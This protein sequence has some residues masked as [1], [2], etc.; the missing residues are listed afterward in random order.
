MQ[1]SHNEGLA[2]HI[3]PESWGLGRKAVSQALTGEGMDWVLSLE[4][5][6]RSECRRLPDSGRQDRPCR[7]RETWPGSAWSQTPVYVPTH[8]AGAA[9]A[10]FLGAKR[11][12][13]GSREIPGFGPGVSQGPRRESARSKTT[14]NEPGKSDRPKVPRKSPNKAG[15]APPVAEEMEG[16]GLAKEKRSHRTRFMGHCAQCR[17]A[18]LQ[19]EVALLRS[20]T[21][22]GASDL[23]QEPGAL[24]SARRDPCG[25]PPE[26][27]VPTALTE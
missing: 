19:H 20:A 1:E 5:V 13:H 16:R 12:L 23:K 3:G 18:D 2:S 15:G 26:R 22:A 6:Y 21:C 27:A 11:L 25:G 24:G 14:M 17:K 9:D 4:N 8:L 10:A 7:Q